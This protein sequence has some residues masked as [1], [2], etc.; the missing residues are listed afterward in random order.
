MFCN[1]CGGKIAE[2]GRFCS[3]CGAKALLP[4][5][6]NESKIS[7]NTNK[8]TEVAKKVGKWYLNALDLRTKCPRCDSKNL[9]KVKPGFWSKYM[10][11]ST[12]V[13]F[14][15]GKRPKTLNVCRDCGFSWEDR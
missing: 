13:W 5:K 9:K 2:D 14:G 10:A 3:N 11:A 15:A 4:D 8:T 12:I 6:Q 1:Q 7:N